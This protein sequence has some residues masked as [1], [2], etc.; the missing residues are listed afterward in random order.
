MRNF[1]TFVFPRPHPARIPARRDTLS[2]RE[3]GKFT[4]ICLFAVITVAAALSTVV[5]ESAPSPA[6]QPSP[7][8]RPAAIDPALWARLQAIDLRVAAI[9]D[10]TADF[11]QQKA[12]PLLKKP[13]V[14]SGMVRVAG[15]TV[16]WDTRLPRPSSVLIR[17]AKIEFYYP[18]QASLEIYDLDQR[19]ANLSA[20]PLMRLNQL[21]TYFNLEPLAVTSLDPAADG[22]SHIA[23][24]LVPRSANL[25]SRLTD[26]RVLID[27]ESGEVSRVEI[28]DPDG[29]RTT[30]RF[31]GTRIN[32][33]LSEADLNLQVPTDVKTSHP[34]E[35]RMT[36]PR[37]SSELAL[38]PN[39]KFEIRSRRAE[40]KFLPVVTCVLP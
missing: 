18:Q 14:S 27:A 6:T 35:G 36:R 9:H 5:A 13:L 31:T 30:I 28:N 38:L 29:E 37:E 21:L 10:L 12:T 7:A 1:A 24:R 40:T 8:T 4:V 17:G 15:T 19:L 3:R 34:L 11:E 16:R 22:A 33:G 26:V 20:S 39:L 25:Q 32:T 2:R 23:L